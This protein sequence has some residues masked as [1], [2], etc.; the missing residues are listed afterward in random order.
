MLGGRRV[1]VV[2]DEALIALELEDIITSH[3]GLT[4]GPVRTNREALALI[5]T[6]AI[7]LAILDL[8]IADGE[9]TPT[10]EK[11]ME[12]GI[13]ILVCTGGILPRTLRLLCPDVPLHRKPMSPER[14]VRELAALGRGD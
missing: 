9:V 12:R 14:L 1:L 3:E 10:A 4:V 11:L 7:D 13:P 6:E 8:N 2:E 5:A